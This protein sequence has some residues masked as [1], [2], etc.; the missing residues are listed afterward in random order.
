ME[1]KEVYV[2]PMVE[3]IE[4]P[5]EQGFATTE[6]KSFTGRTEAT[7][8]KEGTEKL[9]SVMGTWDGPSDNPE[10]S[11]SGSDSWI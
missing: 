5:L 4:L 2:P 3:V 11:T 6:T 9:K 1:E 10:S 8:S 7:Q